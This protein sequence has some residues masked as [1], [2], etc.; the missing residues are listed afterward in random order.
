MRFRPLTDREQTIL[1]MPIIVPM[2]VFMAPFVC[3]AAPFAWSLH[4]FISWNYDRRRAKGWHRWFAWHPVWLSGF[5]YNRKDC[6]AWLEP[7]DRKWN[8]GWDYRHPNE[9]DRWEQRAALAAK[10]TGDE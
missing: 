2:V 5:Y 9:L 7:V 10:G 8:G 3:A 6:Y 1:A 4:K